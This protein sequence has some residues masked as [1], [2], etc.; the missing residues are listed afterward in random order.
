MPCQTL[1]GSTSKLNCEKQP[2]IINVVNRF[3]ELIINSLMNH[4]H[5]LSL[6]MEYNFANIS[7]WYIFSFKANRPIRI[8]NYFFYVKVLQLL[9]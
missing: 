5:T 8:Q 3:T 7:Y 9:T 2:L 1:D 4:C 6:E